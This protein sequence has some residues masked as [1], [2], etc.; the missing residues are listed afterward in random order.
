MAHQPISPE[1][2]Y[3]IPAYE[4]CMLNGHWSVQFLGRF[5]T[6]VVCWNQGHGSF[7]SWR[8]LLKDGS[9]LSGHFLI[10]I[11]I[12]L[13]LVEVVI[14]KP[15]MILAVQNRS[16]Q[17]DSC[18]QAEGSPYCTLLWFA[19]WNC[20]PEVWWSSQ[21][22]SWLWLVNLPPNLKGEIL[23]KKNPSL[24]KKHILKNVPT[25]FKINRRKS[26]LWA[27]LILESPWLVAMTSDEDRS[28]DMIGDQRNC[29]FLADGCPSCSDGNKRRIDITVVNGTFSEPLWRI[30]TKGP[31]LVAHIFQQLSSCWLV[32]PGTILEDEI[33]A[34]DRIDRPLFKE[35]HLNA[36]IRGQSIISTLNLRA[37]N[38]IV[39][40]IQVRKIILPNDL[41]FRLQVGECVSTF[42]WLW[43]WWVMIRSLHGR[44]SA[45]HDGAATQDDTRHHPGQG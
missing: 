26:G 13:F 27:G 4:S 38:G 11:A 17:S 23:P 16:F 12:H 40:H 33:R 32:L 44:G 42:A 37:Q 21:N 41:G 19:V 1:A 7:C 3:M 45:L 6:P 39:A 24:S 30:W 25:K 43:F 29:H 22:F 28:R 5:T 9:G 10:L 18:Q 35:N 31:F 14:S 34:V 20:K 8:L 2:R 36:K 15:A